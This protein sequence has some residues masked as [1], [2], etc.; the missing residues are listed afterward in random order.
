MAWLVAGKW[1][2]AGRLELAETTGK[3]HLEVLSAL[4][5]LNASMLQLEAAGDD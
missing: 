2:A 3:D 4:E 5:L 1:A